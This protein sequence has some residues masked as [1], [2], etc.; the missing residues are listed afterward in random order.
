[1]VAIILFSIL[2]L[3]LFTFCY[4]ILRFYVTMNLVEKRRRLR[5]PG[6]LPEEEPFSRRR[7]FSLNAVKLFENYRKRIDSQTTIAGEPMNLSSDDILMVK[8]ILGV[9]MGLVM[10]LLTQPVPFIVIFIAIG[11]FLPDIWLN[12]RVRKRHKEFIKELPYFLDLLTL[13]VE[14]GLD[15]VAGVDRVIKSLPYKSAIALEFQIFL[16]EISVGVTRRNALRNLAGRIRLLEVENL[17]TALI[18]TDQFG[19]SLGYTLR[20]QSEELR[21]RRFQRAEKLAMQAPIKLLFPLIG[22]IMW[23]VFLILLGPPLISYFFQGNAL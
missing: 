21:N 14:A 13:S 23:G 7:I 16:N 11:F 12:D 1:M 9:C 5:Y 8:F 15:F 17:S 22:F 4:Q 10:L 3:S 19:A 18:Q 2:F 6:I 20:V